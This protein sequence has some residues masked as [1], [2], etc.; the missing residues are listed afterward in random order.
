MIAYCDRRR[1][2]HEFQK[3]S[4]NLL[5]DIF[6]LDLTELFGEGA[7]YH[8][9]HH[10]YAGAGGV[11]ANRREENVGIDQCDRVR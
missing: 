1:G 7:A 10:S 2:I 5:S 8:G 4:E 9:C 6:G 3:Q 11:Q